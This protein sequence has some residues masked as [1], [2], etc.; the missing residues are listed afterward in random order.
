MHS[1]AFTAS[2]LAVLP[3]VS[4]QQIGEIPDLRPKLTTQTC[5]REHGCT[6]HK[7][8]V[9]LDALTHPIEDINTGQS[10]IKPNG[11]LNRDVCSTGEECSQR[12]SIN[13]INPHNHGIQT[14]G[15]SMTMHMYLHVHGG[16][17][18]ISTRV[19]L[20]DEDDEYYDMLKLLGREIS[21]D[22]DVS[23]LPC[24]MN[25][26]IYLS[27]MDKTGGRDRLN[28]AGATYGT[29]YCDAQC[30]NTSAFINGVANVHT[31]RACCNEMDLWEANA[32]A[33]ALT[34]HSCSKPGLYECSGSECDE[35]GI[36][37]KSGCGYNP[38][39]LGAQKYYD[40]Y[41]KVDTTKPFTVVT[42]FLTDDGTTTGTLDEIRR[43]YV[44]N[45]QLIHNA[46]VKFE[47][48]TID[49]ITNP[50]CKSVADSFQ[51][52]GVLATMGEALGRGMVLIFAIW[53][54]VGAYMNWLD[55]GTAGPC[56]MKEGNPD[57]IVKRNPSTSVVSILLDENLC[58]TSA[59]YTLQCQVFS[60]IRWGDIGSTYSHE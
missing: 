38:Y 19:Y 17:K 29:G 33:T 52:R 50:Y 48:S 60:K 56:N 55:A 15:D 5:T 40:Y 9:V 54:D 57:L 39:A 11:E 43:L 27:E 58:E 1:L 31:L 35:D 34:P 20:L 32:V 7:T 3:F 21:F 41:N 47:K 4:S 6:T 44:Q 46:V 28:P 45:G 36:C 2:L 24:G 16:I 22:A 51:Q 30:Y 37:D 8:S 42:E 10:C 14:D 18:S 49:S 26:A 12:C 13:G 59:N 53:N 25:G 23:N